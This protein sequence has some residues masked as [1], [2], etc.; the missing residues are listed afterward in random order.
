MHCS[1]HSNALCAGQTAAGSRHATRK[2]KGGTGT[3]RIKDSADDSSVAAST[4]QAAVKG[5]GKVQKN[6]SRTAKKG[7]SAGRV[8]LSNP[9]VAEIKTAFSILNPH[10][11]SVIGAQDVARVGPLSYMN[12]SGCNMHRAVAYKSACSACEFATI[13]TTSP[14][15]SGTMHA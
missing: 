6:A 3:T 13:K 7:K 4:A 5:K 9:T 14:L 2:Q 12:L 15:V 8:G 11:R 10:K 1:A